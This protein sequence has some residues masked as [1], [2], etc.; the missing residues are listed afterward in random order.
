MYKKALSLSLLIV[1]SPAIMADNF[2]SQSPAQLNASQTNKS[3]HE[4]TSGG[5]GLVV[6]ALAAGPLGAIIG[7]S[8]GVLVGNQ[9]SKAE[10]ITMQSHAIS[11]LEQELSQITIELDKSEKTLQTAHANIE[12]LELSQQQFSKKH[13]E[14]LIQF[15]NSYQFDIYFLTNGAMINAHAQQGL[16]KLAEL[17]RNNPNIHADIEAHSDWRGTNDANNQLASQ[18]LSAV[19]NQLAQAGTQSNQL[20][21]T[22]YGEQSNEHRGSWDE[23]LFYDRRVTITLRYFE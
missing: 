8:M 17:L 3:Q 15:S 18:R 22:N 20:L 16:N 21:T 10:T 19:S 14:D 7:G 2:Y 4:A 6:G 11:E 1:S 12:K 9:Q 5:V 23:A 13:R